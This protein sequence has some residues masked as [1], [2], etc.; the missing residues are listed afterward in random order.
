MQLALCY[1]RVPELLSLGEGISLAA[2]EVFVLVGHLRLFGVI[3]FLDKVK[4]KCTCGQ[5]RCELH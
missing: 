4:N 1:G 3:L 5:V 2:F